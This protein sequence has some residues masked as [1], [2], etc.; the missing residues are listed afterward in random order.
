MGCETCEEGTIVDNDTDNDGICDD[1]EIPG[2]TETNACNYNSL[3]TDEDGSC[4]YIDGICETC[5]EGT[6]VDNDTDDDGICDDDEIPGCDDISACNYDILATDNDGSCIFPDNNCDTC[7]ENGEVVD[8]DIDNDGVC[9]DDEIPGCTDPNACNFN[10]L[11]TDENETCVYVDGIC[12]TCEAGVIVD[13][14]IDNDGVCN[15]DEIPGC[16][17]PNA[18]NYDPDL[19]VLMMMEAVFIVR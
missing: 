3:A 12:D 1:D 14:D 4:I 16:T 6:I 11:A 19:G 7:G 10:L 5:E 8:N 9:D 17:D 18:C 13:N 2:C 15:D